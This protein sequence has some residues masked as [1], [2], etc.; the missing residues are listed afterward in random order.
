M[1]DWRLCF[2]EVISASWMGIW[3]MEKV[4]VKW[5]SCLASEERLHCFVGVLLIVRSTIDVFVSSLLNSAGV[6][7]WVVA[8][9]C[10]LNW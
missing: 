1:I 8:G 5:E 9:R 3:V 7:T 10:N 2:P 6:G 4:V